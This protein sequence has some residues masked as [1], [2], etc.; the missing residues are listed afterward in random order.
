MAYT[1]LQP[2]EIGPN[3]RLNSFINASATIWEK[4]GAQI[5]EP[6]HKA[7]MYDA[8]GNVV[9]ATSGEAAIGLV[10]SST[11]DPIFQN[12]PV[13]ILIKYIGLGNAAAPIAKGDLLTVNADGDLTPAASGDFIFGRAFTA[14]P[15][16]G[17]AVQVQ[18]NQMGYM[19]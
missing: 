6:A 8:N 19:A 5:D 18:I 12:A 13:H 10:L 16:P 7:V 4:A 9:I 3:E 14:A 1:P 15:T 11:L 17:E 2:G